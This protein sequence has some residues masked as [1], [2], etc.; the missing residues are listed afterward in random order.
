MGIV[1]RVPSSRSPRRPHRNF[2]PSTPESQPPHRRRCLRQHIVFRIRWIPLPHLIGAPRPTTDST[3][4]SIVAKVVGRSRY[5]TALFRAWV[6]HNDGAMMPKWI[7]NSV[8]ALVGSCLLTPGVSRRGMRMERK[9]DLVVVDKQQRILKLFRGG[10]ISCA[11]IPIAL[12]FNPQGPHEGDLDTQRCLPDQLAQ[13]SV[14]ICRCTSIIH[15][16]PMIWP[17]SAISQ[18]TLG[19]D[20]MIHGLPNGFT[21]HQIG[22][23]SVG[24]DQRMHRGD[25]RSKSRRYGVW[26]MMG[27]LCSSCPNEL[28]EEVG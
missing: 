27:R 3:L 17:A 10:A 24:L 28:F 1:T 7:I 18:R 9:A 22:H 2:T 14:F 11:N 4:S 5:H 6:S 26:S 21:A 16:P 20:I 13:C 25:E 12:G 23:P 15:G 19:R 8:A